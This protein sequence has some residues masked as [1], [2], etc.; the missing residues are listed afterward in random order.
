MNARALILCLLLPAPMLAQSFAGLGG[1]AGGFAE[2][3]APAGLSF[4]RDHAP[5]PGFR[6]EWWYLTANLRDA[7][8]VEYGAQWTLFRQGLTP[9]VEAEGWDS[10]AIWMGHAAL[11][12]SDRQ[13]VAETFARGGIGQAG[14][15]LAPFDAWIDDWSMASPADASADTAGDALAA[16]TV[17]AHGA[18]F[19]Y[20][21][22]A[23]ADRPPVPEGVGGFSVKSDRGQ[24]SYY[25]SQPFYAVAGTLSIDGRDIPV[26]GQAWLDREWSSQPLAATQPGWDWFALHIDG[27]AKVMVYSMRDTEAPPF[28]LGTW[29][30]ADGTATRLDGEQIAL[31]PLGETEVAGRRVPTRWRIEIADHGL[32]VDTEPLNAQ[33]WMPT[34]YPYWEG[35]ILLSGSTGG[36]GYLEMTGYR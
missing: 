6:V 15:T 33:S 30:D 12:T 25:Y 21:L 7:D 2:V 18:D 31:T 5:H 27:G 4:P 23:T 34:L 22:R 19:G 13:R 35:P 17:R 8:G 32:R 1:E 26:T 24:A 9:G 14:V 16:L 28:V 3:T 29:I 20:A 11:T 10:N 36:R